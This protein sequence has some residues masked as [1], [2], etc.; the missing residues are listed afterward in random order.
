MTRNQ[1]FEKIILEKQ[2]YAINSE[3]EELV[4]EYLYQGLTKEQAAEEAKNRK[5]IKKSEKNCRHAS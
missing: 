4:H 5:L 3:V 2:P 1:D